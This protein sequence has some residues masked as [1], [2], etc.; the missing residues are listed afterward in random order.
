MHAQLVRPD[1]F[2]EPEQRDPGRGDRRPRARPAR[3]ARD[4]DG[5][6]RELQQRVGGTR[7]CRSTSRRRRRDGASRRT[8]TSWAPTPAA[9]STRWGTQVTNVDGRRPRHRARRPVGPR[10]PVGRAPAR[11]RDWRGASAC[12]ATTRAGARSPSS[13]KVQAHQCLPKADHL[14]W[15]EA[16][17]PTLTGATAYRMLFGWPPN[18]VEP[19]DVVL[20]W[21]G[22]GGLGSLAIQLVA[23]AGGRAV[24][25][26]GS[27]REGRVLQDARRRGLR[28]PQATSRT[29]ASRRR[30]TRRSGRTWFDGAKAF[31]K[32]IW[33]V[34]GEK[35]SPRIVF[36]HPAQDTIPTSI[37][38]CRPRRHDRDLRRH[39]RATTRWSTCATSGTC[40]SATR[41]RTCSTTSR[42]RRSTTW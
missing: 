39:H 16:A 29:G 24:A 19:G 4:G 32:A 20:V 5:G 11:T 27:R 26:V 22:S 10:R 1:R 36:E 38:V 31:G 18:T 9:S 35:T 14:T 17:A 41:A 25:V 30:G 34:L 33:D 37:F 40:R 7:V 8:S 6:R 23:N 2:G 12:G 15:E 28:E 13:R 42:P 3:R 21:G